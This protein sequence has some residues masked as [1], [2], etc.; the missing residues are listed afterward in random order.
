[1]DAEANQQP[2]SPAS[3][4]PRDK[5][6][7]TELEKRYGAILAA[8]GEF[9][10]KVERPRGEVPYQEGPAFIE[11]AVSPSYGVSV[12]RIESQLQNLKLRLKLSSD[13]EIG[14][15]THKG[16]VILTVPKA[17]DERYFVDAQELWSRWK[18]PSAGFKIP[19]GEDAAGNIVELDLSNSNSPHL[20]I[21]GVTGSGKSEALLTILHGAARYYPPEELRLWL[22]DP[23][24]T[25][26][27]TLAGLPHTHGA[28]GW[29]AEEAIEL[30]EQAVE[31]MEH[32]YKTFR[33]A[34]S[35]IRNIAEYQAAVGPMARWIIVLDEYA[36]LV[37]DDVERKRIEKCLQRLSQK[38]RAA[39]IHVIVS[40]QKPVVQVVNTVVKG[41]LPGKIALRVNTAIE[42]KVILDETG[43]EKLVGK[44]D[45]IIRAGNGRTRT[46]F[47]RYSI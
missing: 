21:A 22:I 23:K 30:L 47:A 1:V 45:A 37:S 19:V 31:E 14:C 39:G 28:I 8:L 44:G 13:A 27:N 26:L 10:V 3:K 25:E 41:N 36:D 32:R 15:S 7:T 6:P 17:D 24:Q 38:A 4:P 5:M 33:E 2:A 46:Q 43:A 9:N 11:Y 12:N 16:N 29:S 20:L 42:S 40:T 35:N 18:R 34:G